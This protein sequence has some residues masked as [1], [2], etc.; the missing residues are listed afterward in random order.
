MK[1]E[2][3]YPEKVFHYFSE[4]SKI[5]RGSNKEKKISDWIVEFARERNLE[6]V[7]DKAFNVFIRKPATAGYEEYSPL[8]LQ[9]HMDMVWEKN[10]NTQFDFET[11]GIELVAEDGFLKAKGTTLGADNGIA[12]A[13]ALA[14]LDS[15]DLKHPELEIILTTDEEDGMSGVNNLDFGIFSGKTL[16]NLDTEEYGQVYV[17]SAGG[18]RIFN[19]FNFDAEKL[20]DDDT[21]ISVDVKGLL[22]GHSGAEIHLGLGNSNKILTEVLNHLNKKYTLSIMDIDGGEKTNAIPREAVALLA[23]KL[24]DEEVSDFEKLAKLA[25]ENVTKDFKIID[26]SPVIEVKEIKKEELKN[27]GKMSISNT[28]AVISF[29]HEFSNGVIAMSKDIEGLSVFITPKFIEVSTSPSINLGVIKTENKDGKINIKVQSLPRSSVNKSLEKLLNDVKELS[30]KYEVA[31]KTNSPY[32]SW[33]YRKDSKIRDIV[34]N[35]FKKI[36]GKDPEIKAIHAGLECGVFD[37]NM[38]NVDIVSIG[39]NIYGAHTPEE[40]MEIDSVGKTWE[41]LLKAMEDYNIKK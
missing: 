19:E 11:Q 12:V 6:V 5:P 39:P 21:V 10:K 35:S 34:V 4:I 13:Y 14:I 18:A 26:K 15:D 33:E 38:E 24:E 20:E 31:V 40:R 27:Q 30:E 9:G 22:G 23:V 3:L 16:I 25:F 2:N 32:P 1:I 37:N 41:L 28:N 7:Q 36:T 17:S 29:F 8:I